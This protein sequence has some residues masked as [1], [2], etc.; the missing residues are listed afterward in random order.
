MLMFISGVLVPFYLDWG[1]ISYTKIMI[2][3][4]FYVIVVL[5]MEIPTGAI[6]DHL[7][8][9]TAL[10]LAGISSSIATLVYSSV[11]NFYIFFVGEF[12]WALGFALLSGS[13]EAILYDS[14]KE[15]NLEGKS[16]K[17]IGRL[18]SFEMAAIMIAAPIGSLIA[19]KIGLRYAMMFVFFPFFSAFLVALTFKEPRIKS[20]KE[21]KE[22]YIETLKSGI[23]YFKGHKILKILTFDLV[24]INA[25]VFFII[26]MY[27]PLLQKL[28]VPIIYFGFVHALMSG[29][30]IP[31]MNGFDKLEKIFGSK[32]RYLFF[33]A[34][35][36]GICFILLGINK[37][38]FLA[39]I[40]IC[41]TA[42]FGLSRGVLFQSYMNKYIESHNR[43]TV[44][45]TI[46]MLR[47]LV[48]AVIYPLVGLTVEWSLNYSF[49][50]IGTLTIICALFSKVE[51]EHLID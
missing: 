20:E 25:L 6:A 47:S 13:D 5:L 33:S 36:P 16:K 12:F 38:I 49:I 15:I 23:I 30:Q 32:K 9:K 19:S 1:K 28:S 40:I 7:G 8:R 34:L 2:L 48:C 14:L 18:R 42:G 51:E 26:W 4:S 27:Q 46:S 21:G 17:I 22:K 45:S 35:F 31:V 50:I 43:A 29:I 44:I 41:L 11:P 10:V 39:I 37:S 24:S 3:Q